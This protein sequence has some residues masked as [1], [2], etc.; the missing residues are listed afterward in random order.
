MMLPPTNRPNQRPQLFI[1][2]IFIKLLS[3][4]AGDTVDPKTGLAPVAQ[5]SQAGEYFPHHL[6]LSYTGHPNE[7]YWLH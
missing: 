2:T 4:F 6:P 7:D 1:Q 5:N 3:F